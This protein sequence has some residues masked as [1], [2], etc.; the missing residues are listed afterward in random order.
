M[1]PTPAFPLPLPLP[2]KQQK[3]EHFSQNPLTRAGALP[4]ILETPFTTFTRTHHTDT[5]QIA[6][7]DIAQKKLHPPSCPP[8]EAQTT[9]EGRKREKFHQPR[10]TLHR[11]ALTINT[12]IKK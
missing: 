12:L 6:V 8:P 9:D 5:Q 7:K 10:P 2:P 1:S 4:W 11:K 3:G